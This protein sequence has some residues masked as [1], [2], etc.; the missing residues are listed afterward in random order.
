MNIGVVNGPNLDLLGSREPDVYGSASLDDIESMIR[1]LAPE[2]SAEVHFFQSNHEGEILDH[3]K[4]S[5]ASTDG[6]LVNA[7]GLT[8]TSVVLRDGLVA[9]GRPFVE[10]HLSNTSARERFRHRSLLAGAAVGV[11]T[12]FGPQSYLLGLRGLVA[13]VRRAQDQHG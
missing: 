6:Y 7:G 1:S 5:S 11:V 3:L 9:T 12:G 13:H 8:H 4:A 10:V 2:L